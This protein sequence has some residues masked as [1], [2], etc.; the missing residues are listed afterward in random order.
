MDTASRYW[1]LVRLSSSGDCKPQVLP[2]VQTWFESTIATAPEA[3]WPRLIVATWLDG[4]AEADLAQLSLR[5]FITYQIQQVCISLASRFG[6]GYGF[7]KTDLF[8]LVLDDDGRVAPN[9]RPFTLEILETYDPAKAALSTWASRRTN[10]HPELSRMLL[11]KGLYR[12]SD[13]AILNDTTPEQV[14]RILRQYH[15]CSEY[16]VT[17]A[18]AL[19][20]R[21][22]QIYLRDRIAQRRNRQGGRCQTPTAEQLR[23]INPNLSPKEVLTRLQQLAGQLRQYRVH[24]RGGP[25]VAYQSESND[26]ETVAN[27]QASPTPDT[28]DDQDEFLQA[29]RQAMVKELDGAIAA[30][31]QANVDRLQGR[32]PPQ[33]RAYVQGLHLFHCKGLGM[34]KLAPDIGLTSQVQVNRLLNL[35]RLRSDVRHRLLPQLYETV[36]RQ[37]LAYVSADRLKALDQTLETLLAEEV[38]EMLATAAAE[39][40]QPKGRTAKSLFAH[41]LCTTIHPFMPGTES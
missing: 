26:W 11:E 3:D 15:L 4:H 2:Q 18:V 14:R 7:T 30:V 1:Q 39:A 41:Q 5:C 38:D 6:P 25:V 21:Y 17:Q 37:A 22:R 13:W 8:Y 31:I 16:E 32:K 23:E 10:H 35:K 40:Q 34:G 20:E 24:V 9:Y 12:P 33:D 36:R 28:G 19:L 27:A 29:Y